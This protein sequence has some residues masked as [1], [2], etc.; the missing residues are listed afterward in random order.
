[1][2]LGMQWLMLELCYRFLAPP[3]LSLPTFNL[4]PSPTDSTYL[5]PLFFISIATTG[6]LACACMSSRLQYFWFSIFLHL[7]LPDYCLI[8]H[9]LITVCSL[10]FT[11]WYYFFQKKFFDKP[12]QTRFGIPFVCFLCTIYISTIPLLS[13]RYCILLTYLYSSLSSWCLAN[14]FPCR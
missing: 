5:R 2:L 6:L 4:L 13:P 3:S 1:M 12:I 7:A 8:G 9:H 11:F 14:G 10:D